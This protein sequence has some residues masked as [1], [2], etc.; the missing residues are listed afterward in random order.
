MTVPVIGLTLV[1]LFVAAFVKAVIGFGEALLGLPLLTL[2]IGLHT[3]T[4]LIGLIGASLTVLIIAKSWRQIDFGVTRQLV[5]AALIGI[6]V[7]VIGLTRLPDVWATT[8]LGVLLVLVALNNLLKPT[9]RPLHGARWAYVFGFVSG[10][11]GGA[12]T[13]AG[14]PVLLYGALRR[15]PPEQFR[16][17]LQGFFLPVTVMIILTHAGAG[18]WTRDVLLLYV[19]A[20][21]VLTLAF[22]LGARASERLASKTF[23][24]LVYAALIVLGALLIV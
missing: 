24:R 23:E 11:C 21:P 10:V 4:P 5:I 6:P 8:S 15:W 2:V 16:A 12:Y 18:L 20:L 3:A 14:P 1:I 7:G 19:L 17:T 13:I 9:F 22:W